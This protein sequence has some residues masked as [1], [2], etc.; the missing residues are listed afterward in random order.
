MEATSEKPTPSPQTKAI[1]P[2]VADPITAEL[3]RRH[4]AGDKLTPQEFGKIGAFRSK[5]RQAG[6]DLPTAKPSAAALPAGGSA[7]APAPSS[8]IGSDRLPDP[9]VAPELVR[10]TTGAILNR[11]ENISKRFIA[12]EARKAG[13]DQN[14]A[15]K[16]VDAG[17]LDADS[18]GLIV[19]TSPEVFASLGINPESY[20]LTVFFGALSAWGANLAMC[21]MELKE[22]QSE[23][24]A[25]ERKASPQNGST[26]G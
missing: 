1:A 2:P 13:A 25:L 4:S 18:R 16:F 8:P 19:D 9:R 24:I 17:S 7:L 6:V 11:V 12:S 15:Q 10:K 21:V 20:P 26:K 14:L 23:R 22:I 5:Q 3:L